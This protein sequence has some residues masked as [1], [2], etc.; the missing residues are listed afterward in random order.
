MQFFFPLFV[1]VSS[2]IMTTAA[3]IHHVLHKRH[4]VVLRDLPV[5]Q[6]VRPR[7][8]G[9]RLNQVLDKLV[10]YQGMPKVKFR[11]IWLC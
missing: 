11:N 9:H 6:E 2:N 1:V 10:W 8:L 5:F 4:V 7:V 3:V